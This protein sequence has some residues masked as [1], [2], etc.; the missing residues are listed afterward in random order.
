MPSSYLREKTWDLPH[1]PLPNKNFILTWVCFGT[2][3]AMTYLTRA[4]HQAL[5]ATQPGWQRVAVENLRHSLV[6]GERFFT[7]AKLSDDARRVIFLA[8]MHQDG[9]G[10]SRVLLANELR[11][12]FPAGYALAL[13]DRSCG[14]VIPRDATA[15][16]LVGVRALVETMHAGATTPLSSALLSPT[17]FALPAP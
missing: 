3:A 8:F 10:S 12:A 6:E 14:L 1:H 5:E 16:E 9:I 4:E 17:D 7:H 11:Q 2:G 13:P 15:A